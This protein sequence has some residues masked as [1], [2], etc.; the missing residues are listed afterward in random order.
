MSL[1]SMAEQ[2]LAGILQALH[3]LWGVAP[4]GVTRP[5]DLANK[6]NGDYVAADKDTV[7]PIQLANAN[8]VQQAIAYLGNLEQRLARGFLLL[9]ALTRDAERVTAEEV[10]LTAQELETAYAGA[11]SNLALTL[12]LPVAKWLLESTGVKL[13]NS[14]IKVSIITGLDA[15]SR[16]A[17]LEALTRALTIL[18][19]VT[20][21]PP[22][23]QARLKFD[24]L[25][26]HVGQGTGV[27]MAPFLKSEAEVQQDQAQAIETNAAAAGATAAAE[28]AGSQPQ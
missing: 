17:D 13:R 5:E 9:S 2:T 1:S 14:K 7:I 21:L 3:V 12:Q 6:K 28:Q 22:A 23:L 25:A 10:R 15:L 8:A 19:Q 11:Y 24:P 18:G 16:Q 4:S 26:K 27:N 20:A